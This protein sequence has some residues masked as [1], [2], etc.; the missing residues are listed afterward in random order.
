MH[1]RSF[2]VFLTGLNLVL[3]DPQT[4]RIQT[5]S[6]ATTTTIGPLLTPNAVTRR[7][8]TRATTSRRR[9]STT[10]TPLATP[11]RSAGKRGAAFN[12][13]SLTQYFSL[14]GQGSKVNWAYNWAS[15]PYYPGGWTPNSLNGVLTYTPMLWSNADALTSIWNNNVANAIRTYG[16]DAVLAFNEPDGCCCGGSCMNVSTAISAYQQWVQP[17][18]G[19]VLLGAPVR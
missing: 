11:T 19:R 12:D 13:P 14:N 5:T 2:L 9:T 15:D 17:W 4:T 18:A 16:A 7:T 8:R 1:L 6:L 3:S 10:T